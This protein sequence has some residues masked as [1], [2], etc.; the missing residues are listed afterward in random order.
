MH[1]FRSLPFAL[2]VTSLLLL[3]APAGTSAQDPSRDT[4][5]G[6]SRVFGNP[7][8]VAFSSD[9][10]LVIQHSSQGSTSLQFAPAA[11]FFVLQNFSVGG[12]IGIDY[13]S[14]KSSDSTRFNIGPRIG[15]N[16]PFTDLL[17]LWPKLGFS[18]SHTNVSTN[19]NANDTNTDLIA[20]TSGDHITLN[21]FAP[22]MFHP[23]AHFF[24]GFGPFLDA[25]LSGKNKTTTYGGRLTIGGWMDL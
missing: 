8:Q 9:V 22:V 17:G 6:P 19:L 25:D 3:G 10:A 4:G 24:V 18:Y 14:A 2:V 11:D 20:S 23:V 5:G 12:V 16:I 7:S 21:L 15:Y 13:I 1:M